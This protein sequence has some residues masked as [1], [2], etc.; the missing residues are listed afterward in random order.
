MP[1]IDYKANYEHLARVEKQHRETIRQQKEEIE[2]LRRLAETYRNELN[3][4][5]EKAKMK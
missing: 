5:K 2:Y 3:F 4:V 1:D